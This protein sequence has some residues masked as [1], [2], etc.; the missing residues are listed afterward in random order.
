VG[1]DLMAFVILLLAS[2]T[3]DGFT[4]TEPWRDIYEWTTA[5]L[6]FLGDNAPIT[7]QSLGLAV[8]PVVFISVYL[9]FSFAMS[10]LSGSG[11]PAS[12]L[13]RAFIYS[14]VPIALAYHI[15]HFFSFLLIQGQ[16]IVPLASD[17]F[18]Y[19][20]NLFGTANYGV[21]LTIV[22][23]RAVWFVSLGAIVLGHVCAVYLA[24][25]MAMRLFASRSMVLRSQYPMLVLMVLYTTTS[26]WIIA[27]PIVA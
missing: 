3:F 7:A 11:A 15:A 12:H 1:N 5:G 13:A 24:H 8:F 23:S 20:W 4:E 22:N 2:V 18:G 10:R 19:L 21:N 17:P 25:V 26:L 9:I 27:Q 14:L 16:L 6:G